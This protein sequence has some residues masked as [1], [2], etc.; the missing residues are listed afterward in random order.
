MS[1]VVI[2]VDAAPISYYFLS[3]ELLEFWGQK[4]PTVLQGLGL[5]LGARVCLRLG[6]LEF[7]I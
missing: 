5:Q 7:K 6:I 1:R 4:L 3:I 2:P